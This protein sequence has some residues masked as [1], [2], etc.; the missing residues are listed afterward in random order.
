MSCPMLFLPVEYSIKLKFVSAGRLF[1]YPEA[2]DEEKTYTSIAP[3]TY[4]KMR[5]NNPRGCMLTVPDPTVCVW[6]DPTKQDPSADYSDQIFVKYDGDGIMEHANVQVNIYSKEGILYSAVPDASQS[7]CK[8]WRVCKIQGDNIFS[9]NERVVDDPA[10]GGIF[11]IRALLAK[12]HQHEDGEEVTMFFLQL[13]FE[14]VAQSYSLAL[15]QS[16]S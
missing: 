9:T 15:I 12:V 14:T 7:P 6:S 5:G 8:Y 2:G 16:S 13:H 1:E 3:S 10:S 4:M 11:S